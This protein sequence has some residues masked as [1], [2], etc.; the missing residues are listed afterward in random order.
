MRLTVLAP[1]TS[2]KIRN[3]TP[4]FIAVYHK[5]CEAVDFDT[6]ML[7]MKQMDQNQVRHAQSE[8]Q[9][10]CDRTQ[11]ISRKRVVNF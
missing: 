9:G 11:V 7:V 6:L 1:K 3:G 2:N 5:V 4:G 10:H 8:I